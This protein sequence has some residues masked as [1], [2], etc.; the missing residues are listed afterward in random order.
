MKIEF[1]K[2]YFR[3][4][5]EFGIVII[6]TIIAF[7]PILE[8]GWTNWDDGAYVLNNKVIQET[9]WLDLLVLFDP[10]KRVFDTY[11]PLTLIFLAI[12]Y[13][14]SGYDPFLYHLNSL[15][16]HLINLCLVFLICKNLFKEKLVEYF[17]TAVFALH[18]AHVESVAWITERKD[19]LFSV[20]YLLGVLSYLFYSKK[21]KNID[22][23]GV[24][25]DKWY[26]VS[27]AFFLLSILSKPQA[28]TFPI[29]LLLID[30][31]RTSQ[32]SWRNV[33]SKSPFIILSSIFAI[34]SLVYQHDYPFDVGILD[35]IAISLKAFVLYIQ[36]FFFP[37]NLSAL[38]PFQ[39]FE[40]SQLTTIFYTT[41]IAI[42]GF[43]LMAVRNP[44]IRKPMLFGF[45]FFTLHLFPILHLFKVN[46]SIIYERFTYLSYIGMAITV[47]FVLVEVS[48]KIRDRRFIQISF[49]ILITILSIL[50]YQRT[51]VWKNSNTIWSDVIEQFPEDYFAYGNRG[52]YYYQIQDWESALSDYTICLDLNPN[53]ELG[54]NNRG[55][56]RQ[57]LGDHQQAIAD[58]Q[59]SYQLNQGNPGY[60]YNQVKSHVALNNLS[61]A[62]DILSRLIGFNPRSVQLIRE[63]G[64]L[65]QKN[66]GHRAALSDFKKVYEIDPSNPSALYHCSLSLYHLSE[67]AEAQK[68]AEY[69]S[70]NGY[71]VPSDY[72]R[73]L[74]NL[75]ADQN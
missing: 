5:R 43:I 26:Y 57:Q 1:Q 64:L 56:C 2:S 41:F 16:L 13:K 54:Y 20:F 3:Q 69:A 61:S 30:W 73:K 11:T 21:V 68:Y 34:L 47:G 70:N 29:V 67:F 72:I 14:F 25:T 75:V 6:L 32:F 66:E 8:N 51:Q 40:F 4:H 37:F 39:A 49:V 62:I 53:F 17:T 28:I 74:Q 50:T 18:P 15:L 63:R 27:L 52:N 60:L 7:S 12:E 24:F 48:K 44:S 46:S 71:S 35:R 38:Y 45:L 55:L 59:K 22:G 42:G 23:I 65:H 58:F 10:D 36:K 33:Y 31:W 9:K 19:L